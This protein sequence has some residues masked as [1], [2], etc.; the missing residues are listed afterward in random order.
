MSKNNDFL[1]G[2]LFSANQSFLEAKLLSL[3]GSEL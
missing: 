2:L 3:A 1:E